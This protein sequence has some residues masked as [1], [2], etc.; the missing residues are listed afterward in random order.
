MLPSPFQN[1][2]EFR[3][4]F[5]QG[6]EEM[7]RHRELGGFI[8]VLANATFD[9]EIQ[10]LLQPRLR[11]R[12]A[13]LADHYRDLLRNGRRL[14]DAPDDVLVFLKLLAVGFDGLRATDFR[15]AGPWEIQFNQLRS[16]RPPRMSHA[17]VTT[18]QQPFDSAAFHFNKPFLRKE[19]LWEGE[20]AGQHCRLLY[21][22]FP[23]AELHGLLVVAPEACRAQFLER[24]THRW[25]WRLTESL[26]T[27]LPGVG[28]GYNAYGAYA[29]VNHQHFQMYVRDRMFGLG[30]HYPI[31]DPRWCHNGGDQAYPLAVRRCG[32][33]EQ[34]W[35]A[36]AALHGAGRSYNLLYRPGVLYIVPR[37]MQGG[38]EH[39]AWT[40]GFA[41]SE[42]AGALTTFNADDYAALDEAAIR[43]EFAKLALT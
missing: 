28:F 31:E 20:L 3:A 39:A 11:A 7:L 4:A 24:A 16:F 35:A 22:K 12:F 41:W 17:V 27:G 21:N 6:L 5:I 2:R 26:G 32:E 25:L 1:T 34:A 37:A 30:R 15:R 8:L 43:T 14:A 38:F 10:Q 33:V 40:A 23:F 9:P 29:S 19:I 42:T 36:L 18:L 13:E